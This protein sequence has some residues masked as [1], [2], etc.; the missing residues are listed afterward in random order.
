MCIPTDLYTVPISFN[1]IN[2]GY[3][4]RRHLLDGQFSWTR[5]PVTTKRQSHIASIV[6]TVWGISC[7]LYYAI[8][9]FV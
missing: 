6:G 8:D 4:F 2:D 1:D 9:R 7:T 5:L 3:D